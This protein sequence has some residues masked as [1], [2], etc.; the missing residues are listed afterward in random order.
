[1]LSPPAMRASKAAT[2]AGSSAG[3][4]ARVV[5]IGLNVSVRPDV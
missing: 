2:L 4:V 3:G 1:M 5:V